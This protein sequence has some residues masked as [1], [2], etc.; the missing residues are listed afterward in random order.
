MAVDSMVS[1]GC[2][3][4]GALVRRSLLFSNVIIDSQAHLEDAVVLPNVKIGPKA[5]LSRVVIDKGTIIPPGLVVGEDPL[6][7]ARRF[8]R[9]ENGITLITPEMLGQQLH[10]A[11]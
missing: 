10:F 11:R 5:R 1:G 8:Y 3:I 4:S 9:S 2:I 6:E 7:D